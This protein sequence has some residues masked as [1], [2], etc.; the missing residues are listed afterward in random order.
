MPTN[1]TTRV[2]TRK[3]PKQT[4]SNELVAAVLDAAQISEVT[5]ILG[6]DT[7]ERPI[8]AGNTIATV[9][10]GTGPHEKIGVA[11]TVLGQLRRVDRR[12]LF[13]GRR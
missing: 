5:R 10:A 1:R 6:A 4:R 2:S 11:R 7:F 8:Y 9:I 3:D 13:H 12:A